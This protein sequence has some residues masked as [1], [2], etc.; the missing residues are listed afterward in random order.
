MLN[1]FAQTPEALIALDD[2][3]NFTTQ[4]FRVKHCLQWLKTQNLDEDIQLVEFPPD[5]AQLKKLVGKIKLNEYS[6][7]PG[8]ALLLVNR[9]RSSRGIL[10]ELDKLAETE[11]LS[12]P[13]QQLYHRKKN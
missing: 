2:Q 1:S 12:G 7:V 8:L 5:Q 6:L 4:P 13:I 10:H 3:T 9:S 11:H